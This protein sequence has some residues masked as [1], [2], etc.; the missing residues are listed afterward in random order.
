M[1]ELCFAT[2]NLWRLIGK[3]DIFEIISQ[4]NIDGI[5]LTLGKNFNERV[6]TE[7]N[8][9]ICKK[10][11]QNSIHSPFG[12]SLKYIS[13]KEVFDGL[14]ILQEYSKLTNSKY[15]IVHPV[16]TFPKDYFQKAS[17]DFLT[18]NLNPKKGKDRPRLGFEVALNNDPSI[19]LCLDVSHAYDW[20][21]NETEYIVSKWKHKIKQVHFSNNR[22]HKDHLSFEKVG[23]SFIKSIEPL[24]DLNVPIVLEEDMEFSTVKEIKEELERVRKILGF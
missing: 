23:K 20:S 9:E 21:V 19:G 24:K 4:L 13:E 5:E 6:L 15:V 10:Y 8:Q 12:Y 2:G 22:Y 14:K 3:K 1:N 18:E 11:S 16:Q 7:T 17:L